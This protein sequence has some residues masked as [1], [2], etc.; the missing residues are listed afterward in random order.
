V[1]QRLD[2]RGL[3]SDRRLVPFKHLYL[4][5]LIKPERHGWRYDETDRGRSYQHNTDWLWRIAD[6]RVITQANFNKKHE[7]IYREGWF[8]DAA[9][10]GLLRGNY[11]LF[12]TSA[13]LT[14]VAPNPPEV[15][16][17]SDKKPERWTNRL[18]EEMTVKM[19]WSFSTKK[20][21]LR[22]DNPCGRNVHRQIHFKMPPGEAAKWRADLIAALVA[23]GAMAS[24]K[25]DAAR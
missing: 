10:H 1:E 17:S 12:A 5:G 16:R 19:A 13:D 21:D 22:V 2:Q 25:L 7:A 15:A 20:R 6:H 18:F 24:S 11:I 14:F 8:P 9:A 23:P 4:N 3:Q